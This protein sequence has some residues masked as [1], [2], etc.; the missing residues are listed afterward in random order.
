M[1]YGFL[2]TVA[3]FTLIVASTTG[4]SQVGQSPATISVHFALKAGQQPVTCG[5]A[6]SD[7]GIS[8][9]GGKL[10]D[11]RLY[12]SQVMLIN[13]AGEMIL[14]KLSP[15]DWQLPEVALLDFE[16]GSDSCRNGTPAINQDIIGTAPA[17]SYKGIS[18]VIG[19]PDALN[20]TSTETAA[21][22]LDIGAMAWNW[23]AG[24]KFLK[25]EVEPEGGIALPANRRATAW[26]VHIGSTGC[27]GNPAGNDT[28]RCAKSNRIGVAFPNFDPK[29]QQI[30]FDLAELYRGTDLNR[31]NGEAVGCMSS[32]TDKDCV[33][34]FA[35][36]G[37]PLGV[38]GAKPQSGEVNPSI[39]RVESKP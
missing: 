27:I 16:D 14:L 1:K 37:L 15:N 20:H 39:L 17:G 26:F 19:V 28:V 32:P 24:R 5:V 12:V 38:E 34:T 35:R 11:A 10:R 30:V 33:Q 29:S 4:W 7:L 9:V 8:H 23:Q 6:L 31:E 36:L 3:A 13:A 22:P 25:V 21:A 18:F 2:L